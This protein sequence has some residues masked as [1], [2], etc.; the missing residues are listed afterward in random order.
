MT[1]VTSP[2]NRIARFDRRT[3]TQTLITSAS[4]LL[5][6]ASPNGQ[7]V[8]YRAQNG[9]DNTKVMILDAYAGASYQAAE[10]N[11]ASTLRPLMAA[12]S[13]DGN[14]VTY[15]TESGFHMWRGNQLVE[16]ELASGC[17]ATMSANGEI[18]A[19]YGQGIFEPNE[20]K[21]EWIHIDHPND[22][23]LIDVGSYGDIFGMTRVSLSGLQLS[24]DGSSIF[25]QSSVKP[26]VVPLEDGP[27][28]HA[29]T[30]R[31]IY[32]YTQNLDGSHR[33]YIEEMKP[34][35]G[36]SAR[37]QQV[38]LVGDATFFA[39]NPEIL[40]GEGVFKWAHSSPI[41]TLMKR[42]N[43]LT[44]EV[45]VTTGTKKRFYAAGDFDSLG[46]GLAVIPY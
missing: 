44:G 34:Y 28:S 3:A 7:F 12:V 13:N 46:A 36:Q 14:V 17:D 38:G 15:S 33:R 37:S 24:H 42:A 11:S 4:A 26:D 21:A 5:L 8:A 32:L 19:F 2:D 39:P 25:F 16:R 45:G 29:G 6:G 43:T 1:Y 35:E 23:H 41:T 9:A 20:W 22:D 31:G 27:A 10:H 30:F 40:G 18:I